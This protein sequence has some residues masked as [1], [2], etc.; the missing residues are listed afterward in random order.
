MT[1][2]WIDAVCYELIDSS[3]YNDPFE[4]CDAL[5]PGDAARCYDKYMY[6]TITGEKRACYAD[7]TWNNWG[8]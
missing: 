2:I 1:H 4:L 3:C 8:I 7:Q 5:R 6:C